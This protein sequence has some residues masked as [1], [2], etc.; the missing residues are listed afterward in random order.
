MSVALYATRNWLKMKTGLT[1]VFR[2]RELLRSAPGNGVVPL[3]FPQ[4]IQDGI[5]NF[6]INKG[7]EF[8]TSELTGLIQKN[9]NYLFVKRFTAKEEKRRLQVGIYLSDRLPEYDI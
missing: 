5:V 2:N 3:F 9:K 6:P 1:V 7:D 4:H 8:I